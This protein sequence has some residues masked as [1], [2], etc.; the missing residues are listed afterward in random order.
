MKIAFSGGTGRHTQAQASAMGSRKTMDP[1]IYFPSGWR[2]TSII[3]KVAANHASEKTEIVLYHA[4]KQKFNSKY[5]SN[6]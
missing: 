2:T 1:P 5:C 3:S 6:Y 4:I